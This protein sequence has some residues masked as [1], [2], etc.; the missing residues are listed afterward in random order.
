MAAPQIQF[1]AVTKYHCT[2]IYWST[3]GGQTWHEPEDAPIAVA[4]AWQ[5]LQA[6]Q[7]AGTK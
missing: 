7:Q 4:Q 5:A 3:D 1:Q 6:R 2:K